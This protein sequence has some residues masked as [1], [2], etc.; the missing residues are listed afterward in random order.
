MKA[1][2][3]ALILCV[4]LYSVDAE[5]IPILELEPTLAIPSHKEYEKALREMTR[6]SEGVVKPAFYKKLVIHISP[7]E[8]NAVVFDDLDEF[9]Q[10]VFMLFYSELVLDNLEKLSRQWLKELAVISVIDAPKDKPTMKNILDFKRRLQKIRHDHHNRHE[11]LAKSIFEKFKDKISRK[12][13]DEYMRKLQ[14]RA[15]CAVK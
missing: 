9:D 5:E 12:E 8:K 4:L 11:K 1:F 10:H 14:K 2:L 13:Q 7:N 6:V 3:T 15:T